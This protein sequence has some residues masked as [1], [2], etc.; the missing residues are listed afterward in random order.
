[1][2][3]ALRF[4]IIQN[5]RSVLNNLAVRRFNHGYNEAANMRQYPARIVWMSSP[6]LCDGNTVTAHKG[7]RLTR[8]E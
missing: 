1:M 4:Q 8:V 3:K 2:A 6:A 7:A 5:I